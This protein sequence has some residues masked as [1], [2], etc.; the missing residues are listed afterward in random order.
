VNIIPPSHQ[1]GL[2]GG[3]VL[4]PLPYPNRVRVFVRV[5]GG[6]GDMELLEGNFNIFHVEEEEDETLHI[7]LYGLLL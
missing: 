7:A 4:V 1:N 2:Q 6:G 5:V 3:T